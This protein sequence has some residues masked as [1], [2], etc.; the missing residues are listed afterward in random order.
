MAKRFKNFRNAPFDDEWGNLKGEDRW[1][2]KQKG[3]NRKFKRQRKM[4][5]KLYNFKEYS[6]WD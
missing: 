3:K 2:E 5:E 6:D 1:R 4:D